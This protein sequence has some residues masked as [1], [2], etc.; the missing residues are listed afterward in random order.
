VLRGVNPRGVVGHARTMSGRGRG[1]QG[2]LRCS[3]GIRAV[4][5]AR[6][7]PCNGMGDPHCDGLAGAGVHVGEGRVRVALV[8]KNTGPSGTGK[9]M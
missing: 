1:R 5:R 4:G 7:Q 2:G 6:G 9:G 3:Y 8:M